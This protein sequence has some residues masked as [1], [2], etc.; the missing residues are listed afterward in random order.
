MEQ[1]KIAIGIEFG[2]TR[3][4][5]VALNERA[6]TLASGEY[7]WENEYI[8][9]FWSYSLKKAEEGLSTCFARLKAN[10]KK[11]FK[12]PLV[13][14][15]AIGISGMMHGYLVLDEEDHQLS[16]FR[17]WRNTI[18]PEE[19]DELTEA[20]GFHIPQRWSICHI[21]QAIKLRPEEAKRIAFA[22]TLAG[23]FHYRLTGQKV[24][25]VGE[26]S[27]IFPID[28]ET[29]SYDQ[30]M[31]EAFEGL[32]KGTVPWR[33][34]D[35]LPRALPAGANAGILTEEGAKLLD[36][37]GS[38]LPGVMLVPPEGDMQTGMACT[39]S[40]RAGTGNISLGTSSNTTILTSKKLGVHKEIDVIV[41]P[42]G[43]QAAL[44]HVN[45]CTT[46]LNHW[47][48]LFQ[49]VIAL[50][51]GQ[52][53]TGELF[54]RLFNEAL[55]A[56]EDAGGL[57]SYNYYS[58]EAIS[59]IY[60]GRPLIVIPPNAKLSLA[61]FMR[62]H[63]F[64]LLGTVRMGVDILEKEE[65]VKIEKIYGHG[66][67]FKTPVVGQLMLSSALN[68]P[69][70]IS[71]LA[72][73]GGPF[74]M[75]LLARY[76]LDKIEEETLEDFLEKRIFVDISTSCLMAS[77]EQREGFLRFYESYRTCLELERKATE[78]VKVR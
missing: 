9:S 1:K 64:S 39:N 67:F 22:T 43:V 11:R 52:I 16:P 6:E 53:K 18:T 41:S 73:E 75:A 74:G 56:E 70:E 19:S 51:G 35:I 21:Y 76:A 26:A 32:T 42:T 49:E 72:G 30:R 7:E 29:L 63:L 17:T 65:G 44:I 60:E 46:D 78:L 62:M 71:P 24:V 28:P 45:N 15:G 55:H 25:G 3:I 27:G 54:W 48:S 50:S 5:A 13:S 57:L 59:G 66:G 37:S 36:P 20:F 40:C 34:L 68:C 23:Y 10:F 47:V 69:V 38:F 77:P 14:A 4:K 31:V 33:L 8:D 12:E 58:G 2:S 61:N